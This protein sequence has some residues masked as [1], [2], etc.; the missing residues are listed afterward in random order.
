MP[1][2]RITA[3]PAEW[4]NDPAGLSIA[5]G[6]SVPRRALADSSPLLAPGATRQSSPQD[7]PDSIRHSHVKLAARVRWEVGQAVSRHCPTGRRLS[8]TKPEAAPGDRGCAVRLKRRARWLM[9]QARDHQAAR[10]R[11]RLEIGARLR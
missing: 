8:R 11:R 1:N 9:D 10:R 6:L 2:V 4:L 3:Y 5:I 7:R